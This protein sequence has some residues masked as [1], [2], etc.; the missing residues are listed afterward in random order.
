MFTHD[1]IKSYF[2]YNDVTGIIKWKIAPPRTNIKEGD[3]AGSV[4]ACRRVHISLKGKRFY[5]HQLAWFYMTGEWPA[6]NIGHLDGNR[7]NNSFSNLFLYLKIDKN[8]NIVQ[9][10]LLRV[11]DYNEE[12]GIFTWKTPL[13][14]IV[15]PGEV[16]GSLHKERGY[17]VIFINNIWYAAH[18]LAYLYMEGKFP[19][20]TLQVDHI[21]RVRSNN[22]WNNLR[23]VTDTEN[24][25]NRGLNSNNTSGIKGLSYSGGMYISQFTANKVIYRK[26]FKLEKDATQWLH[27]ER[28]LRHK[29]YHCHG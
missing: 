25:W 13:S 10:D 6:L 11:L 4:T 7:L 8:K 1:F 21:D 2:D 27:T 3:I 22:S 29:E 28:E 18:R 5:G 23:L 17:V 20:K 12:T 24:A 26:E 9:E 19:D 15:R 16:A 14:G